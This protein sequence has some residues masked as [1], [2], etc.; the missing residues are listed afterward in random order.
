MTVT[1]GAVT[2]DQVLDVERPFPVRLRPSAL[3]DD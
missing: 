3:L 1:V 2:G